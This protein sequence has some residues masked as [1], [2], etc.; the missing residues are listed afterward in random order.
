MHENNEI[1]FETRS[2]TEAM[3]SSIIKIK[4]IFDEEGLFFGLIMGVIRNN[5]RWKITPLE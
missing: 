1:K 3:A 2:D 5:K 4:E